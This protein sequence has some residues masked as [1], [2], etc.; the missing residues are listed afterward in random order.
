[1]S[2]EIGA[3]RVGIKLT[4]YYHSETT[5]DSDPEGLGI[6]L[7]S[8]LSKL[9]ILFLH[10]SEPRMVKKTDDQYVTPP[11]RLHSIRK[12][13]KGTFIASGGYNKSEGDKAVEENYADLI[14][15]G[16]LFL[17]NPDLPK[18]FELNASLNK[19]DRKTFYTRDPVVGYTDYPFLGVAS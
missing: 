13:F 4:P 3:E 18:R 5:G 15:F 16:R 8:E 11:R 6:Y 1:M 2:K 17:A 10:V 14:S 12:A 19:H 7:S 9:G